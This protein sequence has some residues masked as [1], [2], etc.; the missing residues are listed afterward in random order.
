MILLLLILFVFFGFKNT[1]ACVALLGIIP[2]V[3]IIN[4]WKKRSFNK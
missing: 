2:V 1:A 4:Q 3:M